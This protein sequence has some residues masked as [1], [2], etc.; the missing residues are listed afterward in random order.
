MKDTLELLDLAA[1]A[2]GWI[3]YP[4][5]SSEQGNYWHTDLARAPFGPTFPKSAWNPDT[6]DGDCARMEAALGINVE[7]HPDWVLSRP[8]KAPPVA[9]R[10]ADHGGDRN[11]A[12]R[13]SSLVAAG[14]IGRARPELQPGE[15]SMT[16]MDGKTYIYRTGDPC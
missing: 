12:R 13:Q 8:S 2:Q 6:D 10:Y 1:R 9:V 3:D 5:D 4:E 15:D 7:W 11:A 14:I 16:T